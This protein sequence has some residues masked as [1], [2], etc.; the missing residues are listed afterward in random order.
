M[1]RRRGRQASPKAQPAGRRSP[2]FFP[3][4]QKKALVS[5]QGRRPFVP[6]VFTGILVVCQGFRELLSSQSLA[7][8][9]L[10]KPTQLWF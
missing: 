9:F 10:E 4:G 2:A 7:Q 5:F 1:P 3:G 6:D 8:R